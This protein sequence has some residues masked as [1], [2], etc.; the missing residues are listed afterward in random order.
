[1]KEANWNEISKSQVNYCLEYS[2]LLPTFCILEEA[3]GSAD[4]A[5]AELLQ[6]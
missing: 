3:Y 1:M 5:D 6:D 4:L 2:N